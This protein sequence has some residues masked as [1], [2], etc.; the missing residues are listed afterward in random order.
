M[1]RRDFKARRCARATVPSTPDSAEI[2]AAAATGAR[3]VERI[4]A[5]RE[6][7]FS[8]MAMIDLATDSLD[9]VQD[10]SLHRVLSDAYELLNDA[11]SELHEIGHVLVPSEVAN[12]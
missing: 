7:M 12:G 10:Y 4:E 1:A 6:V 5:Q 11:A 2:P 9:I 8:A 3:A